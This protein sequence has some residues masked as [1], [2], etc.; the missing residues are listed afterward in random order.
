MSA[1]PGLLS[2]PPPRTQLPH[3]PAN[4]TDSPPLTHPGRLTWHSFLSA[5]WFMSLYFQAKYQLRFLWGLTAA[6]LGFHSSILTGGG[7]GERDEGQEEA[8]GSSRGSMGAPCG[9]GVGTG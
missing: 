1:H 7:G 6:A 5:R 8:L 2:D 3:E 9:D 4:P